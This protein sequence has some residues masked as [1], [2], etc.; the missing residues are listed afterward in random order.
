[1]NLYDLALQL[2]DLLENNKT[3]FMRTEPEVPDFTIKSAFKLIIFSSNKNIDV[4]VTAENLVAIAAQLDCTIF[5]KEFVDRLYAWN[6]KSI[7][8]YF[9][10][11]CQRYL[12]PTANIIDLHIIENFLGIKK[13]RPEN[14]L[15]AVNRAKEAVLNK[16]WLKLY[17]PLYL[18]LALKVLPSIETKPLLNECVKSLQFPYYEIEGQTNGRM[19]CLKKYSKCYIPHRIG[20]DD[21]NNLKPRGYGYRF[22][23]ADFR[24][25]EVTVLQWLTGDS[26]LKDLLESGQDLHV[27]IYQELTGDACDTDKKR[28]IS[29]SIFLPVMYGCGPSSLSKQCNLPEDVCKDLIL[30]IRSKFKIAWDWMMLKQN[31]AKSKGEIRDYFDRPRKFAEKECYLARNFAVQGVAA[32]VCQEKLV[33][34]FGALTEPSKAYIAYSVHDGFGIVT[35]T[36]AARDSYKTVKSVLET[37]S[38]FCSGLKMKVVIKFGAKLNS[39]KVLWKD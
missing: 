2:S 14:L 23:A 6:F 32:T 22:L 9:H 13:N 29:K 12:I 4:E 8:T 31:E 18:P 19:N 25:C 38:K 11:L 27:G 24:H 34:L 39:M 37:E 16:G 3:V 21:R 17:K 5:N 26:K 10:F 36:Q 7:A 30:R 33:D 1:M 15:E 28:E 35:Q 20:P